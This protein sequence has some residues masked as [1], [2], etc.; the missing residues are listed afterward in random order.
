MYK[1]LDN[2]HFAYVGGNWKEKQIEFSMRNF[3]VFTIL[4]DSVP[5]IIK[6][7]IINNEKIFFNIGDKLSGLQNV[8]A[9]LNGEWLLL[10][11]DPK[12]NLYWAEKLDS[13][14][15][16]HGEF[17]L[18]VTDNANNKKVYTTKIN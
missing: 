3:G 13:S 10:A 9:T 8:R 18:E 14:A 12:K 16:Y 1:V 4:E 7:L 5:P 15:K 11:N 2:N 6:P 17:V